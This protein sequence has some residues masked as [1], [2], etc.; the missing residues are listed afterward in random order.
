[1]ELHAE[2]GGFLRYPDF[3]LMTTCPLISAIP[4]IKLSW[5]MKMKVE[6]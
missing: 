3:H 6:D 5:K 2:K 4:D 1:M